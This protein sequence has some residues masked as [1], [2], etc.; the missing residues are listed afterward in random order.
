[1][2]SQDEV[3]VYLWG[4]ENFFK[5]TGKILQI[6]DIDEECDQPTTEQLNLALKDSKRQY[7]VQRARLANADNGVV[8][9]LFVP[10]NEF[11]LDEVFGYI[12]LSCFF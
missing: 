6:A 1:M 2:K 5:K 11:S 10:K 3:L 7:S 12:S 8:G 4:N 9:P